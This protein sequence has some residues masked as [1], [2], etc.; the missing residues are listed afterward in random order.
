[1][2]IT[3]QAAYLFNREQL[4]RALAQH[5]Q[6]REDADRIQ[7]T[8]LAFLDGDAA[9]ANGLQFNQPPIDVEEVADGQD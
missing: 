5:I 2:K 3:S 6:G 9:K 7:T 4:L 8:V 1:M